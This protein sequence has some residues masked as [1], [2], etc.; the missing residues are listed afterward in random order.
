MTFDESID[1]EL[2]E[3]VRSLAGA[4]GYAD[5]IGIVEAAGACR[6]EGQDGLLIWGYIYHNELHFLP[7]E[8][9]A[10]S[11]YTSVADELTE[12]EYKR[13]TQA[14]GASS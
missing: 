10:R 2:A 3:Q 9:P 13:L 11:V 5:A 8:G 4:K 14:G 6:L 7:L 12:A 1:A